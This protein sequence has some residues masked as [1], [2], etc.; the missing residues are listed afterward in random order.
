MVP[1]LHLFHRSVSRL[2]GSLLPLSD[3]F[4][5]GTLSPFLPSPFTVA[6][7]PP[8]SFFFPLSRRLLLPLPLSLPLP[9]PPF[10]SFLGSHDGP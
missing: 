7:F 3:V 9:L 1:A 6:V 4:F 5:L 8:L 2:V 10:R